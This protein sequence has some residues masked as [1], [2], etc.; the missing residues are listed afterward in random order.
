MDCCCLVAKSYPTLCNPMDCSPPDFSVHGIS[1]QE[2]WSGLPF[3]SPGDLS[4][5]GIKP[6]SPTLASRFFTTEPPGKPLM[7]GCF[8]Q[9][10]SAIIMPWKIIILRCHVTFSPFSNFPRVPKF[11]LQLD[12]LNLDSVKVHT[13]YSMMSLIIFP[14]R[15]VH[16]VLT[17]LPLILCCWRKQA[18][19]L[20]GYPIFQISLCLWDGI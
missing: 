16:P 9:N 7:Y 13:L 12:R 3:S 6:E 14:S 18:S 1:Q 2:Y 20:V 5:P 19:Y 10:P 15:V 17:L 8:L 4:N 11:F